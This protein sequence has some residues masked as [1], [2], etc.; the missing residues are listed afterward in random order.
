MINITDKTKCTGCGACVNICPKSAIDFREDKA[1]YRYPIVNK[2]KC[3]D[4]SL[5]EKV[6]PIINPLS[7]EENYKEPIVKAAWN[8]D[9]EIRV[10]STSGGV[11]SAI[12]DK[13][14]EDG[15]YVIGAEYTEDFGIRHVVIDSKEKIKRI[16]QSKYAQSDLGDVFKTIKKLLKADK[17]VLFCG[18]PCQAAGLKKYLNK[19]YNNLFLVDFICRGIISQKIYKKYLDSV[20]RR[21]NSKITKVHFKNK[22]FGWNRFST[23]L[24]LANGE[25]YH[26]DRY[27][28]EYMVGYLKYNL[29]LRPC[30]HDCKFKTLPRVSD[31]SLGDFWGIANSDASLD[32]DQG[33]SVVMINSEKGL[34]YFNE[35]SEMLFST[36]STIDEVVKGNSCLL[37]IAPKGEYSDYFYKNFRKKDFIELIHKIEKKDY[38]KRLNF[39]EKIYY[40]IKR[41]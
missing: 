33:T 1:G 32:N 37:S 12:A 36:D 19:S 9:E 31:I 23:K 29:Y 38:F 28:D 26:K 25:K 21:S 40:L 8:I 39:K 35:L 16:R 22:D 27:H 6:C 5:C 4:C 18:S 20:E 30:C 13:F 17:K 24:S 10:N 14:I 15:G 3:V 41:K 7:T 2:S 34:S 11:F